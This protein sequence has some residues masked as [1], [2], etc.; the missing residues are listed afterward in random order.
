VVHAAQHLAAGGESPAVDVA[1]LLED[2][3]AARERLGE[4]PALRPGAAVRF[5]LRVAARQHL[6]GHRAVEA[7]DEVGR[8]VVG[9]AERRVQVRRRRERDARHVGERGLG[10]EDG[11]GVALVVEPAPA[12]AARELGVLPRGQ[13]RAARAPV[14]AEA[15]DDDGARRHV[16]P[17]RERLGREHD[18]EQ[19]LE[20]ALLDGELHGRDEAG[21][22]GRDAAL[23][24]LDPLVPAERLEVLV[25][26]VL[27]ALLGDGADA[28][29]RGPVEQAH[30]LPDALAHRV[31]ARRPRED[32]VDAGQQVLVLQELDHLG[33]PWRADGDVRGRVPLA[34]ERRGRPLAAHG[35]QDAVDA[36]AL[37]RDRLVVEEV[38]QHRLV[39]V[40]PLEGH[41]V[42]Q[43]DRASALDDDL[44]RAAH[45]RQP[46]PQHDGVGDRRR[47][48]DER[49]VGRG[50][51]EDLLPHPAAV[52]V[53]E[54][55][56]LV[57]DDDAEP[58]ELGAPGQQHVA[59]HLG[60]HHDDRRARADGRVAGEQADRL[61]AV[62]LAQVG[63]LLVRQRLERRRV[64]GLAP[65]GPRA[66]HGVGGDERLARAGGGAHEDRAAAVERVERLA[67]EGVEREA[68]RGGERL[69]DRRR[70][71]L[72]SFPTPMA[73]K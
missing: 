54:E 17:E 65:F 21:V 52:G 29:P 15:L 71:F 20:E 27:G 26:E 73:P 59:Q 48:A 22:V 12:R 51:D 9:R 31:L 6:V 63:E 18:A 16:D 39:V 47:Q 67:L 37:G 23:E 1:E 25:A 42:V 40:A 72:S 38:Q 57:E 36:P 34:A 33:A 60:R 14:L 62:L 10:V 44:E 41:V 30:P 13:R 56:D 43:V 32:E 24:R 69:A 50:E 8:Q 4:R 28:A 70:H 55:V 49:D 46:L 11:H 64:E 66:V 2:A 53:L 35:A 45:R 58:V 19:P 61:L 68:E 7:P 5:E 3:E